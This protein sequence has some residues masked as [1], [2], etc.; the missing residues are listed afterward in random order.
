M[1]FNIYY[2][3]YSHFSHQHVSAAIATIFSVI[4]LLEY[5]GTN[6]VSC[7]VSPYQLKIISV[8]SM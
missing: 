6:L 7:I 1:H 4:L 2:V 5:N 8:K 3:F